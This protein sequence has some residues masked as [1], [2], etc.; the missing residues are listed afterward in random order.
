MQPLEFDGYVK[1][2]KIERNVAIQIGSAIGLMN[3]CRL[4][5]TL[6][7]VKRKRSNR[8]N[9]YYW[10]LVVPLIRQMFEDGGNVVDEDEIHGFLKE[11][12]GKLTKVIID[13]SGTRRK[14]VRSS[15]ETDTAEFEDYLT[16]VRAWAAEMGCS[17]PEPNELP[18]NHQPTE[19]P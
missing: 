17:I 5:V 8:Q 19:H 6:K 12:V 2:G 4:L 15:T 7:Q 10:G 18:V 16:K 9:R 1:D 3:D 13:P 14:V 11:H